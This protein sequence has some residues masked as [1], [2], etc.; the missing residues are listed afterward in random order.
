MKWTDENI[1]KLFQQNAEKASFEYKPEYWEA[2]NATLPN[3]QSPSDLNDA[4]LDALFKESADAIPVHYKNEFWEEFSASLPIM[5][6]TE[7]VT[8]GEVDAL[9]RASAQD[10]AFEYKPSYW[11]EMVALLNRRRRPDL[12]WFGLSGIFATLILGMMFFPQHPLTV[13]NMTATVDVNGQNIP[14]A[15]YINGQLTSET[16]HT[17]PETTTNILLAANSNG[18]NHQSSAS[19]GTVL[20]VDTNNGAV[21]EVGA[22]Q[23]NGTPAQTGNAP[24][25][26]ATTSHVGNNVSTRI[27]R[28]GLPEF[29]MVQNPI[30]MTSN[31][32]QAEENDVTLP[33]ELAPKEIE[34][35]AT[36]ETTGSI[37]PIPLPKA[38]NSARVQPY[39]QGIVGLSQS[40]ITPSDD[41][42]Y[43]YGLGMGIQTHQ[44]NFTFT[45][46]INVLLENYNDLHLS[47]SAKVYGFGS[48]LYQFDLHYKQLYTAEFDFQIGYNWRRHQFN[49]GVRP[50]YT[51]GSRVDVAES[52]LTSQNG[53]MVENSMTRTEVYG[54][55][56]GIQ[57]WGVRPTIGYA[58]NFPGNW[59]LGATFSVELLPAINEEFINGVNNRLPLDG[60]LYLRKNF[61]FKR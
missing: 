20:T 1:D 36:N 55:M 32:R 45:T 17:T 22:S 48:D 15:T 37:L 51:F 47:R 28:K 54:F 26:G 7:E 13:P 50:S 57:Q 4:E 61:N 43:S 19:N 39:I 27:P 14:L 41:H 24:E 29:G 52:S 16:E 23:T 46:G 40:M 44:R 21:I 25:N 2:F 56:E 11:N 59:A 10:L 8:D 18:T 3:A 49:L 30:R 33:N 5:V 6:A 31:E 58:F 38:Q 42:S 9:Y 35:L 53:Q 60:Q 12:L 34:A